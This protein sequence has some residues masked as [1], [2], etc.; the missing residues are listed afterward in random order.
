MSL[1]NMKP[2]VMEG[3]VAKELDRLTG[4]GVRIVVDLSVMEAWALI[5]ASQIFYSEFLMGRGTRS[6][7]YYAGTRISRLLLAHSE[8]LAQ[9][10]K[11]FW[12]RHLSRL[13]D[14]DGVREL[15]A[16][17][18]VLFIQSPMEIPMIS[19]EGVATICTNGSEPN[20]ATS[21]IS[22][23]RPMT[24]KEGDWRY[25]QLTYTFSDRRIVLHAWIDMII[26]ADEMMVMF[27]PIAIQLPVP[28]PGQPR[29]P[30]TPWD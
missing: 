4:N 5:A 19:I 6:D 25:E 9:V 13:R 18:D 20:E 23:E 28:D 24:Y 12:M 22:F 14:R 21:T 2:T 1:S 16:V 7:T 27:S 10:A 26:S 3:N 11:Q 15:V 30:M 29:P 8:D 17:Q